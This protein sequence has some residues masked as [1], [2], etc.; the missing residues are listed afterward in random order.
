LSHTESLEPDDM[1][2][3][4]TDGYADQFG[5]P[6]GKKY[7]FRRFRHLLLNVHKYPLDVQRKLL[8]G[9][10]NEWKGDMEQVDDILIIGIKPEVE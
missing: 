9:S 4:F 3:M 6:E 1:I 7:K 2:Y 5:G 8:I 10:I